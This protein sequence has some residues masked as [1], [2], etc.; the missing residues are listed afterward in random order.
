[1][2]CALLSLLLMAP[3]GLLAEGMGQTV[4]GTVSEK[5]SGLT[6]PG[7]AVWVDSLMERAVVSD[8]EGRFRL[9]DVPPGRHVVN[10][11]A[12]GYRSRGVGVLVTAGKEVVLALELEEQVVV[13]EA[14]T[15]KGR[16]DK[17]RSQNAMASVSAR[18]F[19][20]DE[21]RRYAGA[22]GDPSRM[23][24]NFAGVSTASDARNDIIIRG[25]SPLGLLW[26]LNGIDIPNPNHFGSLGSTGGPVS[27]LN[28]NTLDQ[29]DFLT[30]AFPA[31][32]GNATSGVF[33]LNLRKGNDERFE[34]LA[35][36]G[37]N[38][39]EAGVEGP[40]KRS[41]HASFL[42]N[43]RYSTLG[44]FQRVGI[45][46]GTGMAVPNYQ[47]LT[48]KVDWPTARAGVFSV[49]AVGG[50]SSIALLDSEKESNA[51]NLYARQGKDIYYGSRMGVAGITHRLRYGRNAFGT[52]RLAAS[53]FGNPIRQLDYDSRTR[54][55]TPSYGNRSDQMKLS[56]HYQVQ[57]RVGARSL[58]RWGLM[59]DR[60]SFVLE[61]SVLRSGSFV[62]L[63]NTRGATVL[64]QAY[65]QWQWSFTETLRMNLGGHAQWL[66]LNGSWALEPRVGLQWQVKA[67]HQ[68]SLGAGVHNQMQPLF[69]YYN[70]TP[71]SGG[72]LQEG[73]RSLGFS[74]S[75]QVV[76]AYDWMPNAQ[77]R[78]KVEAYVQYLDR[79]PVQAFRGTFS[80]LNLGA[81]FGS[82]GEDSLRNKG[83]GLNQGVEFT[84]ERFLYKGF[85]GLATL[86]LFDSRYRAGN[87]RWYNTAFNGRYV[88]NLLVGREFRLA[89]RTTFNVDLRA[90]VAGGRRITPVDLA[91]SQAAGRA[92]FLSEQSFSESL[93]AYRRADV[94]LFFRFNRKRL[95]HE[96]GVDAQNVLNHRNVFLREFDPFTGQVAT[97]YQLGLLVIPQY[98]LL[99]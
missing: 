67:G 70:L 58:W 36:V 35:Q 71:I 60:V 30:G 55:L 3:L 45:Q 81:D 65:A 43:Y 66:D 32:Y 47:D 7:V 57:H 31:E 40:L 89:S 9:G 27:I 69:I 86:S 14:V 28:S 53:G 91:A 12:L 42:A 59:A 24:A 64:G 1:M 4:R 10:A 83:L 25:N 63:R 11:R 74:R 23:A 39:F 49:F 17:S 8:G 92:V 82:P 6:L 90:S 2:K 33:D 20:L 13:R 75:T 56:L 29:S 88:I 87:D 96:V 46:F 98:R 51:V 34:Y 19:T 80:V 94:R 22:L 97:R 93:P 52:L 77:F 54:V 79:I 41:S 26:R 38:G 85:Y 50:V 5:G 95:T 18:G 72:G 78:I 21:A 76:A 68:L 16:S 61:D 48:F 99:F 44:F 84:A 73:N 37:F 15:I 62:T